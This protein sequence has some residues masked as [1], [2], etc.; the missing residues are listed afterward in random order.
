MTKNFSRRKFL[1]SGLA[2]AA[3]LGSGLI[4]FG[5]AA[6]PHEEKGY[7]DGDAGASMYFVDSAGG[8]DANDG[9]S[10]DTAWQSLKRVEN[11]ALMPG[12]TVRF[13]RGSNFDKPLY[14]RDSGKP[15]RHILLTDYGE[16]NMPAPAFT[17]EVFDPSAEMFGNCIRLQGSY[18]IVEN[19]YFHHTVAELP[20]DAGRFLVMWEL[21]AVYIDKDAAHCIVRNNEIFDC[22]VGIK[23]Y[24]KYARIE[25]NYIHDCNRVLKKWGWGPLG[26]WLGGDYQEV[27]YNRIIN[28]SVVD[29]RINWGPGSYGGGAD[30]GAI[31]I[32]DGRFEK[33]H[34]HIHHNYTKDCQGFI[35]VTWTD[36]V[37]HPAYNNFWIHHNVCD[38]YQQFIALWQGAGCRIE[39]NTIVR[40]KTNPTEWGVFNITQFDSRNIIRN[41]IVAVEKGIEIFLLGRDGNAQPNTI[42]ENNLYFAADGNL[43][44]G[45]DGPGESAIIADPMFR[46][47]HG[48]SGA[49]DFAL[50][51]SSPAIDKGLNLGHRND[52]AGVRIPQRVF[53]DLGAFEFLGEV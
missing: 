27:C 47:Y 5:F 31:E 41:N 28:Y 2:G 20:V 46:N 49:S 53:P 6:Q 19:L 48:E 43:N 21:G 12:D 40:R 22:G 24:G 30:G 9:L 52:F 15:G 39:N 18:I 51:V 1:H 14:I 38:D 35:E 32:D 36:V 45:L 26:I 7:A 13:R 23:S 10:P 11:A 4:R 17:N 50:T 29:S 37:Q 8:N 16:S 3:V 44:I 33:S 34:I 25:N 42:I